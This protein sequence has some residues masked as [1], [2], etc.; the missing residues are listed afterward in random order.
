M[1]ATR[2]PKAPPARP[3]TPKTTP[4]LAEE[5]LTKDQSGRTVIQDFCPLAVLCR[6]GVLAAPPGRYVVRQLDAME[7]EKYLPGD[8]LFRGHKGAPLRAVFLNYL[9]DCLPAA[10]LELDGEQVN[11]LHVRT[12]LARNVR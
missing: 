7:P 10:V 3:A 6:H 5:V 11:E 9:L 8:A 2:V 1:T 12:V 4:S